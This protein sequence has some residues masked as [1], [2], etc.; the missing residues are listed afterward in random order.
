MLAKSSREVDLAKDLRELLLL[1][2]EGAGKCR[3]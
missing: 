1:V 2:N 3:R